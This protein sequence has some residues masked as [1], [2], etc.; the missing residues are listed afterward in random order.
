[1]VPRKN[2]SYTY[3]CKQV[4]SP[5]TAQTAHLFARTLLFCVAPKPPRQPLRRNNSLRV[6]LR[7][8]LLLAICCQRSSMQAAP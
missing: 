8:R 6:V 3:V 5:P 7:P 2:S 1:M 4:Q